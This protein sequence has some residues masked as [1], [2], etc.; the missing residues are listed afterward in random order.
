ML[1]YFNKLKDYRKQCFSIYIIQ[2]N[3][4]RQIHTYLKKITYSSVR[5]LIRH[6]TANNIE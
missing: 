6:K 5:L 4:E 3:F 1:I 2:H